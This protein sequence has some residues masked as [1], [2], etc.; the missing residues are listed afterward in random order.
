MNKLQFLNYCVSGR[1]PGSISSSPVE[2]LPITTTTGRNPGQEAI[3]K[4]LAEL[5]VVI[6]S[7]RKGPSLEA[8]FFIFCNISF[9]LGMDFSPAGHQ[10]STRIRSN[11]FRLVISHLQV[12]KIVKISINVKAIQIFQFLR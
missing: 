4:L 8:H 10:A 1:W 5:Q 6:C 7:T 2:L 12:E 11:H 3:K 9:K